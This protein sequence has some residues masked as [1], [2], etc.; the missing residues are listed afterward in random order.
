[1]AVLVRMFREMRFKGDI[2]TPFDPSAESHQREDVQRSFEPFR[3]VCH[4]GEVCQGEGVLR[5]IHTVWY[6][7]QQDMQCIF[8]FLLPPFHTAICLIIQVT[9]SRSHVPQQHYEEFCSSISRQGFR[10]ISTRG[11][12]A[13][14]RLREE[15]SPCWR[16]RRGQEVCRQYLASV[17]RYLSVQERRG[18]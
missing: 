17:P 13:C 15:L 4:G 2:L 8:S 7:R 18:V 14:E 9:T 3:S 5:S 12:A 6:I 16:E 11:V 1:M 10:T